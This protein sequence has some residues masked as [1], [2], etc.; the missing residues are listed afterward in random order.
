MAWMRA[1]G[2]NRAELAAGGVAGMAV[3]ELE[4]QTRLPCLLA[5]QPAGSKLQ[6]ARP[7]H[8]APA[9]CPL[10]IR[11]GGGADTDTGAKRR[12]SPQPAAHR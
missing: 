4:I 5:I 7:R 1:R 3:W 11:P 2:F 12:K 6:K 8:A 10:A 9:S